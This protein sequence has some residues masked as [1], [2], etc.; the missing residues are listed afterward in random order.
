MIIVLQT[1]AIWLQSLNHLA[2]GKNEP[3]HCVH[4]ILD[5]LELCL[6]YR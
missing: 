6:Q 5:E 3:I 1:R 2:G 4:S